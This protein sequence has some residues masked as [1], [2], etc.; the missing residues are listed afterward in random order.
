[1]TLDELIKKLEKAR[2]DL[3][4]DIEFLFIKLIFNFTPKFVKNGEINNAR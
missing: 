3:G 2:Q 4:G 1:M